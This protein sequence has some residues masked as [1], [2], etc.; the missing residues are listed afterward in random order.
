MHVALSVTKSITTKSQLLL[1]SQMKDINILSGFSILLPVSC[2]GV[3][4]GV[5]GSMATRI[6]ATGQISIG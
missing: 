4:L 1:F 5:L 2:P 6:V 3:V